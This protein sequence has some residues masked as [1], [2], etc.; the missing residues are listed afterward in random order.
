MTRGRLLVHAGLLVALAAL[1]PAADASEASPAVDRV[2]VDPRLPSEGG[3]VSVRVV[4]DG[5]LGHDRARLHVLVDHA[6]GETELEPEPVPAG[7][8]EVM[9]LAFWDAEEPGPFEVTG[10]VHVGDERVELPA[11]D[12]LVRSGSPDG[13]APS[14]PHPLAPGT[15]LWAT[16]FAGLALAAYLARP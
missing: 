1:A 8:D 14:V 6:D 11:R 7:G 4:V 10:H 2:E 13:S 12:G 15:V 9:L 3:S 16:A 5:V